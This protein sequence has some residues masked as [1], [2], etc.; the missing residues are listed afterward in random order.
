MHKLASLESPTNH[1]T[2]S[3]IKEGAVRTCAQKCNRKEPLEPDHLKD[4]ASQTNFEELLQLR[5]LVMYVLLFCSFLRSAKI[6]EL[7]RSNILFKSD[8]MEISI[9]K[10]KTDQ[11]R[12]GEILVI[13]K[14]EG[15]L[16][17]VDLLQSYL[18]KVGIPG[19]STDSKKQKKLIS[20]DRHI[21]YSTYRESFKVSFKGIVPNFSKYSTHSTR[22]GRCDYCGQFRR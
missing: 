20:S 13:A 14:T 8:H 19:N 16:C 5:S 10:S 3:L 15:D 7:C 6:L 17:L 1:P 9:V 4:L 21:S 2:T 18:S 22:S 12:E 11:L